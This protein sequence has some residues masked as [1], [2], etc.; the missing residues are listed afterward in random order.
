MN[1]FLIGSLN[2]TPAP[3]PPD[4]SDVSPP[5]PPLPP[6]STSPDREDSENIVKMFLSKSDING[7]FQ[8]SK[9]TLDKSKATSNAGVYKEKI[10]NSGREL[11]HLNK[12][13]VTSQGKTDNRNGS[14]IF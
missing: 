4:T 10:S 14:A 1:D 2:Q 8:F 11:N 5:P 12:T 3:H 13:I 7:L 6:L 9:I